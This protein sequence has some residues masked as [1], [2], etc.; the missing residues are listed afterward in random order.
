MNYAGI[1]TDDI[2][3]GIGVR[4]TLF[5]SGCPHHCLGCHNPQTWNFHYGNPFTEE[6]MQKIIDLVKQK[7]IDGLTLSGGDPLVKENISV[8]RSIVERVKEETGKSIWCYTGY[9]IDELCDI[10]DGCKDTSYVLSNIDVLVDGKFVLEKKD[11]TLPFR[12]SSNQC[13]I[14]M[15]HSGK[16]HVVH[17]EIED[18]HE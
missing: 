18:D 9:T 7:E 17:Y 14:D 15:R 6:T 16:L 1:I 4:V 8:V 10:A 13:I 11:I 2:V 12:G 3:D 5:V